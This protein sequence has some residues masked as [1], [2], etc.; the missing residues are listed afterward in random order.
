M[1][2]SPEVQ[3]EWLQIIFSF[4]PN[5][6]QIFEIFFKQLEGDKSIIIRRSQ[7]KHR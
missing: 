7:S 4:S 1:L 3:L 5:I 2:L 6:S